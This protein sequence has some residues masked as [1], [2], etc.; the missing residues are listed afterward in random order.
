MSLMLLLMVMILRL[1][2]PA[3]LGIF[4]MALTS[5]TYC[6]STKTTTVTTA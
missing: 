5:D 6:T 3:A 1:K 4:N 2:L